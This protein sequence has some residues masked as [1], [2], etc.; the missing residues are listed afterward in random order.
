[1]AKLGDRVTFLAPLLHHTETVKDGK[2]IG[3]SIYCVDQCEFAGIVG[4]IYEVESP[5]EATEELGL[6]ARYDVADLFLLV[7]GKTGQWVK[8]IR[9]GDEAGEFVVVRG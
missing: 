6:P 8:G 3:G 7:P 9:E 4:K 2:T 1:M 5:P